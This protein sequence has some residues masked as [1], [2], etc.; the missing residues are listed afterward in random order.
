MSGITFL[1]EATDKSVDFIDLVARM[2]TAQKTYFKNRTQSNLLEAKNYE[3]QVDVALRNTTLFRIHEEDRQ[4]ALIE[5]KRD[6]G[7]RIT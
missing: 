1:D 4:P 5:R 7:K 2:R 6:E 3:A